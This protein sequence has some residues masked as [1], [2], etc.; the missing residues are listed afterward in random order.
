MFPC[1]ERRH[2]DLFVDDMTGAVINR[3]KFR[4]ASAHHFLKLH[5]IVINGNR[6]G[7]KS[8]HRLSEI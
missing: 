3:S 6:S 2:S 1:D 7:Y 4:L 8:K 5:S